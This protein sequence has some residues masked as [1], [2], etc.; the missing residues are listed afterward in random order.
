MRPILWVLVATLLGGCLPEKPE[1][2]PAAD[3]GSATTANAPTRF[4]FWEVA[5]RTDEFQR[6]IPNSKYVRH[7]YGLTGHWTRGGSDAGLIYVYPR[8]V[9]NGD[10]YFSFWTSNRFSSENREGPMAGTTIDARVL[11]ADGTKTYLSA[12]SWHRDILLPNNQSDYP[13]IRPSILNILTY[14]QKGEVRFYILTHTGSLRREYTVTVSESERTHLREALVAA[15]LLSGEHITDHVPPGFE[16]YPTPINHA[17]GVFFGVNDNTNK[18]YTFSLLSQNHPQCRSG[19]GTAYVE[20]SDPKD[21]FIY[22]WRMSGKETVVVES[23][24]LQDYS[25]SLPLQHFIKSPD[26]DVF[27]RLEKMITEDSSADQ[28]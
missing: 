27:V 17:I 23:F 2:Q 11:T 12:Q 14:P 26:F 18:L 22:C 6:P 4:G 10:V 9:A 28:H 21:K 25:V 3:S 8:I 24:N 19:T 13:R 7:R 5:I 16:H 20:G 1:P 15:G